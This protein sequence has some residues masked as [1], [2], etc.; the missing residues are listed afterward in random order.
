MPCHCLAFK[1]SKSA[2]KRDCA[3]ASESKLVS[4]AS[5]VS[6]C[7]V[8]YLHWPSCI[9]EW[10]MGCQQH[11]A[12][13]VTSQSQCSCPVNCCQIHYARSPA[14]NKSI[15]ACTQSQCVQA[16]RQWCWQQVVIAQQEAGWT[17]PG[18]RFQVCL[19]KLFIICQN[20]AGDIYQ[21]S[22]YI[23]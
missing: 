10:A 16:W 8:Q 3:A 9:Q 6:C 19:N 5:S 23:L 1:S 7:P 21:I 18:T 22:G 15:G 14:Y 12:P 4:L 17:T 2:S 11:T 13:G 20:A